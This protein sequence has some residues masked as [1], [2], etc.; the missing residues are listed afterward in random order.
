MPDFCRRVTTRFFNILKTCTFCTNVRVT[1]SAALQ[2]FP[3]IINK[4][5][6]PVFRRYMYLL[7]MKVEDQYHV[8]TLLTH[9]WSFAVSSTI[10]VIFI[11]SHRSQIR[12]S[13]MYVDQLSFVLSKILFKGAR[14]ADCFFEQIR[15]KV[16][17]CAFSYLAKK[18]SSYLRT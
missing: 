18:I 7:C 6:F 17:P 5:N 4:E 10:I 16:S 12:T 2:G 14:L 3:F 8:S 11:E 15:A 9:A 13:L 1:L